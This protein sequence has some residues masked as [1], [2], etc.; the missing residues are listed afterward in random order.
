MLLSCYTF[1][2][3]HAFTSYHG[4]RFVYA[5]V[6]SDHATWWLCVTV[7]SL[8]LN[9]TCGDCIWQLHFYIWSGHVIVWDCYSFTSDQNMW[10][11]CVTVTALHLIT[12]FGDC[13]WLLQLYIWSRHV[14]IVCDCYSFTF[15]HDMWWLCITVTFLHLITTCGDCVWLLQLYIWSRHVVIVCDCYILTSDHDMW[16]SCVTVTA[17]QDYWCHKYARITTPMFSFSWFLMSLTCVFTTFL[18]S[19]CVII[20]IMPV[21]VFASRLYSSSGLL[22]SSTHAFA[23]PV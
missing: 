22:M 2:F 7:T 17:L 6:T 4:M 18:F 12:T 16:W 3:N 21:Y 5:T 23:I 13:V 8:Q 10:W 19:A 20:V 9:T 15:N 11:L 1:T 14:V